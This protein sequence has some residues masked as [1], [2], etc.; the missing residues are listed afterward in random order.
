M[1]FKAHLFLIVSGLW[2]LQISYFRGA[3]S[4]ILIKNLLN[5]SLAL[6]YQC[7]KK[8]LLLINSLLS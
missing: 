6:E 7:Q 1:I 4:H 2:R 8:I 5:I 3:V